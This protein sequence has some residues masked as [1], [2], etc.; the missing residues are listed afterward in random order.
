MNI[1]NRKQIVSAKSILLLLCLL[2]AGNSYANFCSSLSSPFLPSVK[3]SIQLCKKSYAIAYN[4]KTKQA[5]YSVYYVK[6]DS[7]KTRIDREDN[8]RSDDTLPSGCQSHLSDYKRSGYDRGHLV[9]YASVDD[10]QQSADES[11]LLSNI[12]PQKASLNRQGWAELEKDVRRWSQLK[13]GLL[14]YSGPIYK[15][16]VANKY[17]GKGLAVPDYFFKI[18]YSPKDHQ[19]ISFVMPNSKVSRKDVSKYRVSISNIEQRIGLS[20]LNF[21]SPQEKSKVSTMCPLYYKR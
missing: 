20:F 5:N 12:S 14:V 2:L 9:P 16:K 10:N 6:P 21:L 18:V 11:F 3:S 15:K 1:N 19:T 13:S 4:C 17:I 8:F 7:I